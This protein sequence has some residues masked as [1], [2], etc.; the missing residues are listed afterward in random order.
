MAAYHRIPVYFAMRVHFN[1]TGTVRQTV[2]SSWGM[3]VV[4]VY[5]GH[6]KK[7]YKI[8]ILARAIFL[9]AALTN[10]IAIAHAQ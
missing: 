8:L 7:I 1:S 5:L 9:Q 6:I 3:L 2:A 4:V 10:L